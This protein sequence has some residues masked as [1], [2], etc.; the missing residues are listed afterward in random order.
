MKSLAVVAAVLLAAST[1]DAGH[2]GFIIPPAEVDVGAGTPSGSAVI[3]P[4]TE[5]L[6]G[7]HWA[8]L[9]WH[10]TRVD[11]GIG[12]VGSFRQVLPDYALR[13]VD[14]NVKSELSLNGAYLSLGYAIES[15][16]YW[17]TWLDARVE[18][19]HASVNNQD[20]NA[21]GAALRIASEVYVSGAAGDGGGGSVVG[22]AGTFALGVYVEAVH[23]DLPAE[24][25][26]NGVCAGLSMRIPF[27]IAAG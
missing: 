9:Y 17:R 3:G 10:P 21:L 13:A 1:A 6:A 2:G 4:S 7:V 18:T 14:P 8:S 11:V 23:R 25:G 5:V 26:P 15:H 24:L 27:I 16:P 22:V 19:L 20:F 12:Y